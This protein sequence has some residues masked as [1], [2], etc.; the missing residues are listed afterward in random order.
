[1]GNPVKVYIYDLTNGMAKTLGPALIGK[2]HA[3]KGK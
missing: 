3:R 1:M 2:F